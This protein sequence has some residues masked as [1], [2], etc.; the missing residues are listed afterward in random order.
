MINLT[1]KAVKKLQEFITPEE[2]IRIGVEG[3]GCA[4]FQYKFGLVPL[5]DTFPDDTVIE[6]DVVKVHVDAISLEYLQ[7]CEI[8]YEES[9]F[10]STF[11]IRNPDVKTTC[12]CGESWS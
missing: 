2:V 8:D 7:N 10:A 3:G 6:E 9:T 5:E 4:G 11:K 1:K 12:G